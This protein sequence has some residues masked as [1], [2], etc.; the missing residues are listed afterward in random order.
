MAS[1][2]RSSVVEV[3][4]STCIPGLRSATH[5]TKQTGLTVSAYPWTVTVVPCTDPV[6]TE[7]LASTTSVTTALSPLPSSTTRVIPASGGA[8][9]RSM[10]R[11]SSAAGASGGAVSRTPHP[12]RAR[13]RVPNTESESVFMM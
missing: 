6:E 3:N 9:R 2:C 10:T 5:G 1:L 4:R 8:V 13:A 12:P 7:E 11:G